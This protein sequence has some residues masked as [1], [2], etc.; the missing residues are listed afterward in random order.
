MRQLDKN[1][2]TIHVF[3]GTINK[4]NVIENGEVVL[5]PPLHRVRNSGIAIRVLDHY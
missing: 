5:T 4:S 2:A 3:S 1:A